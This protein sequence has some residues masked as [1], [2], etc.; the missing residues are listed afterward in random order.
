MQ[1]LG[2]SHWRTVERWVKSGQ[3]YGH[4]REHE[5]K[6]APKGGHPGKT[7]QWIFH[8][9]GVRRFILMYPLEIDLR[10]VDQTWF[11]DIITEG[12]FGEN[13]RDLEEEREMK[14]GRL[15]GHVE[16]E[17]PPGAEDFDEEDDAEIDER[18]PGDLPPVE[19]W[20]RAE[21]AF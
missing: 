12:N 6:N 4:W 9:R 18:S 11:F 7:G 2:I 19:D 10:K 8:R 17:L 21:A 13:F 20:R 5:T 1:G 16:T 14:R 3:L 15:R